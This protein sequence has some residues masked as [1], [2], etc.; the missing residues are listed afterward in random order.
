MS[1]KYD[2]NSGKKSILI[3]ET[4][5]KKLKDYSLVVDVP[6][7]IIIEKVLEEYIETKT[8]QIKRK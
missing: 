2:K 7:Y 8:K 1:Q 4:V 3:S 5:H 6:L